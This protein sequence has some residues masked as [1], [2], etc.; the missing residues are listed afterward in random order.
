[1]S[2]AT[3]DTFVW[4]AR[5]PHDAPARPK[6]SF[7]EKL[8]RPTRQFVSV[9]LDKTVHWDPRAL[10]SLLAAERLNFDSSLLSAKRMVDVQGDPNYVAYKTEVARWMLEVCAE[11]GTDFNVLPLA[12]SYLNRVLAVQRVPAANLQGLA[13][14]CVFVA[15]KM[16]APLPIVARRLSEY[17]DGFNWEM[18]ILN[19]MQW[20]LSLQTAFEFFD[21]LLVRAPALEAIRTSFCSL[22]YNIQIGGLR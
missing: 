18:A 3:M 22:A 10:H 20:N 13:A 16:K 11:E 8:N 5:H 6:H 14:A 19:L 21:Q 2:T 17:T 1:M 4:Q 7:E 12:V 15:S 9:D